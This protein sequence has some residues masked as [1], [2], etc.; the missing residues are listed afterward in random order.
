MSIWQEITGT[1]SN[2]PAAVGQ[3]AES[4]Y[5][6]A[7]GSHANNTFG[8]GSYVSAAA[9]EAGAGGVPGAAAVQSAGNV[10]ANT[11]GKVVAAATGLVDS[12]LITIGI[13]AVVVLGAVFYFTRG[14]KP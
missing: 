4:Y 3:T 10:V 12:K 13:T 9:V 14:G 5:N 2:L 8:A 6:A 1:I 7:T 11:G